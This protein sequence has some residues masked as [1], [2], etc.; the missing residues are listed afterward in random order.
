MAKAV[1]GCMNPEC[2]ANQEKANFDLSYDHCPKC[3]LKLSYVCKDC[4]M[5]LDDDTKKCCLRC[6]SRRKDDREQMGKV[7]V[8]KLGVGAKALG[9]F[10]VDVGKKMTAIYDDFADDIKDRAEKKKQA[11][12]DTKNTGDLSDNG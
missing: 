5:E 8:G 11:N 4:R 12:A 2:I 3:G 7:I 6:E 9:D 1:K 10:A